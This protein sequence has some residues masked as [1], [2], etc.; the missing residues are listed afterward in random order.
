MILYL[1]VLFILLCIILFI[2]NRESVKEP[3]VNKET[4]S[5]EEPET[6]EI[7]EEE[8]KEFL[9]KILRSF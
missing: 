9:E 2:V 4:F 5:V 7:S 3:L 1:V 6:F 8:V